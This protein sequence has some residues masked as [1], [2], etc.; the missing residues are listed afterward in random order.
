MAKL[1]ATLLLVPDAHAQTPASPNAGTYVWTKTDPST[2]KTTAQSPA[3]SGGQWFS[4]YYQ[5]PGPFSY[6]SSSGSGDSYGGG[7]GTGDSSGQINSSGDI[8]T[9]FTWS[10]PNNP[11]DPPPPCLMLQTS[12]AQFYGAPPFA[13]PPSIADGLG[14]TPTEDD[15]EGYGYVSGTKY[16]IGQPSSGQITIGLTGATA[17][18]NPVS[19][20]YTFGSTV[21]YQVDAYTIVIS[22]PNPLGRPDQGDGTN[23]FVY[24]ATTPNGLLNFPGSILIAGAG[25]AGTA[26]LMRDPKDINGPHVGLTLDLPAESVAQNWNLYD[27]TILSSVSA[28]NIAVKYGAYSGP[29]GSMGDGF[30]YAGLPKMNSGFGNHLVT[31]T[32]DGKPTT[33]PA[34]IQTFF[35]ALANNYPSAVT[36]Y[37]ASSTDPTQRFYTPNWFYYYNQVYTATGQY[38]PGNQTYT[39]FS[40]SPYAIHIEDQ[41]YGTIGGIHVYA[42]KPGDNKISWAGDIQLSGVWLY[43]M[44]CAHEKEHQNAC[45]DGTYAVDATSPSKPL[46]LTSDGDR[47]DNT[48]EDN[49]YF[50]S[51]LPNTTGAPAYGNE[52]DAP[53]DEA[54]ADIVGLGNL[55]NAMDDW[56]QDWAGVQSGGNYAGGVQFG[57]SHLAVKPGASQ[58][59]PYFTFTPVTKNKDNSFSQGTPIK[60]W[61]KSDLT[62]A[63]PNLMVSLLAKPNRP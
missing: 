61:S 48:W 9:V 39:D 57:T 32:V 6:E 13:S 4:G 31:L 53:D 15:A 56:K 36:D 55:L 62:T 54:I 3:F 46:M 51:T 33:Q 43:I 30:L 37:T 45:S 22:T 47:L 41:T 24:D 34:H 8:S 18:V 19:R 14:D 21:D 63:V 52:T 11:A 28:D 23:Q 38:Q 10:D 16:S 42:L 5:P 29:S 40:A 12:T 58:P 2:G 25:A 17:S 26:W 27:H 59:T 49:H 35:S 20:S 1:A 60:I 50:D 44:V 7:T